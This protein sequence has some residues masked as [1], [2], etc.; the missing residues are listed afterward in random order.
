MYNG[1]TIARQTSSLLHVYT[2][3]AIK[4]GDHATKNILNISQDTYAQF[5]QGRDITLSDQ[6][7]EY[8][9]D[10]QF[11]IKYQDIAFAVGLKQGSH[12]KNQLDKC[13]RIAG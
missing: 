1:L 8:L 10:G 13:Y 2:N 12:L 7:Q 11:I 5:A 3:F 4:V 6:E 9:E